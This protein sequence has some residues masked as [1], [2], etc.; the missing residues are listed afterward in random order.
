MNWKEYEKTIHDYLTKQYPDFKI[1]HN[2]TIVGKMSKSDRQ[3]DIL[4]DET[5]AGHRI[6]IVIDSKFY[7]DTKIDVKDVESFLGMLADCEA[8]K[9]ILITTKGFTKG[10]MN[11]AFFDSNKEL[12]LDVINFDDLKQFD[13]F[14]AII[15]K[16]NC[17]A[18]ITAPFGWIIDGERHHPDFLA[19]FYQRGLD[20][21]IAAQNKEWIYAS[22]EVKSENTKSLKDFLMFQKDY[23]KRDLLDSKIE[24]EEREI[25]RDKTITFREISY[26][27]CEHR[28]ITGF[29][30][31]DDFIFYAVLISPKE[32]YVKNIRKLEF[33]LDRVLPI[34]VNHADKNVG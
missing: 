3:I 1:L 5:I 31:F 6:R 28:E 29:I 26:D 8:H 14:G 2:Q 21:M 27:K 33:I 15:H 25:S 17:G 34:T 30:E 12:E 13:G 10:A 20:L 19:A 9:G 18:I 23:T 24:Y 4:I 32:L 22:I 16:G 11:R 7:K